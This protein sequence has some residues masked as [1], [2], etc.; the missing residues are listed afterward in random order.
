MNNIFVISEHGKIVLDTSCF[1]NNVLL[2]HFRCT[3]KT[4]PDVKIP[5]WVK[6]YSSD[7]QYDADD[8]LT[9]AMEY[10]SNNNKVLFVV[11]E[12]IRAQGLRFVYGYAHLKNNVAVISIARLQESWY[13]KVKNDTLF[14]DRLSKVV[15]HE[16]THTFGVGHCK[17]FYCIMNTVGGIKSLDDLSTRYCWNCKLK[18]N[19]KLAHE[20]I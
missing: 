15:K 12:D 14:Y 19:D 2:K 16:I 1:I 4:L 7:I 20:Y 13:G 18:I 3:V 5:K 9:L 6:F 17:D 8:L 11:N 10:Q